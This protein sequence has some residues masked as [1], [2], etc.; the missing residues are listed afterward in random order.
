MFAHTHIGGNPSDQDTERSLADAFS[1]IRRNQ[2]D[3]DTSSRY[4]RTGSGCFLLCAMNFCAF[5]GLTPSSSALQQSHCLDAAAV[6]LRSVPTSL[7]FF[8]QSPFGMLMEAI[9]LPPF[10]ALLKAQLACLQEHISLLVKT[11]H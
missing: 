3:L 6:L 10:K 9:T 8:P 11:V 7:P 2:S 5:S 4:T 1:G